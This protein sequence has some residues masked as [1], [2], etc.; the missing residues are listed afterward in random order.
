M[1]CKLVGLAECFMN[2]MMPPFLI[3][4]RIESERKLLELLAP[5]PSFVDAVFDKVM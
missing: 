2:S 3:E 5:K 4:L 1:V